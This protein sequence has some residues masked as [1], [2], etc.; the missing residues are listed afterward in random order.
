[1]RS[2]MPLGMQHAMPQ[3]LI[4]GMPHHGMPLA[5]PRMAGGAATPNIPAAI[6]SET[7]AKMRYQQVAAEYDQ[8]KHFGISPEVAE[9]SE[10]HG[11][12]DRATKALDEEM[13]KRKETFEADMQALWV[14]LEGAKNPS[15]LLMIKL[16]DMRMGTFRGMSALDRTIQEYAKQHRLDTQAAVKLGEV[17]DKR[18]DPEGDM[19][20]I[21]KHLERSNKPSSL[22]MMMLRDLRDGKPVKEPEYGAAIGSKAHERELRTE[23]PRSGSR[24]R[25]GRA[26]GR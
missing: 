7:L 26:V 18:E 10:Y 12:D 6:D 19:K 9:L 17:M 8:Q 5:M 3:N 15:G 13:K 1:M 16:K 24:G 4:P 11:L 20:K 21:A 2:N 22:V 14:G 25:G 23:R